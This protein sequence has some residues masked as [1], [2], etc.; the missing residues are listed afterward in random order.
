MICTIKMII[1]PEDAGVK[2]D[3]RELISKFKTPI[4]WKGRKPLFV[5]DNF[6]VFGHNDELKIT[7]SLAKYFNGNNI[8]NLEWTDVE[9]AFNRL[10]KQIGIPLDNSKI[11]RLDIAANLELKYNVYD[12]F[13]ELFHLDYYQ[14]IHKQK[15]TLRFENNSHKFN[16]CFYDKIAELKENKSIPNLDY[17]FISK[18]INLMRVELQIQE[19]V[20]LF[21]K[22][23]S[24]RVK[25]LFSASF[26]KD[27]IKKWFDLYK[28][29]QKRA[30][31]RPSKGIKG[32]RDFDI[33]MRRREI[34]KSGW[35]E[36]DYLLNKHYESEN[37]KSAKSKKRKQYKD[38]MFDNNLFMTQNNIYDL[39]HKMKVMYVEALKQIFKLK[40]NKPV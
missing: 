39:N 37:L 7:G 29:I 12:Y 32:S 22:K 27:L 25:H 14:R 1:T 5:I 20:A 38:A 8:K 2:W 21:M 11:S 35:S 3:T 9:K 40:E 15:S 4:K 6:L 19:K 17:Y 18:D 10:S 36:I 31:L 13:I 30:V 24:V 28:K 16:Y 33:F 26:C 34:E 23:K